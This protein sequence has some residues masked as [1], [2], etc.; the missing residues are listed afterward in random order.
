ME[1]GDF[2]L[3]NV[4]TV[5]GTKETHTHTHFLRAYMLVYVRGKY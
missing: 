3:D 5:V 2:I 4:S 1:K